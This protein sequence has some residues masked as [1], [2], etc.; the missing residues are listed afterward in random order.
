MQA[1]DWYDPLVHPDWAQ[2]PGPSVQVPAIAGIGSCT[3]CHSQTGGGGRFPQL[4]SQIF[5][6]CGTVLEQVL[7]HFGKLS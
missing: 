1:D 7:E 4:S 2:N 6:Y 5:G 3:S